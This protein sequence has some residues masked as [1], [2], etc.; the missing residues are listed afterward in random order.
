MLSKKDCQSRRSLTCGVNY[1]KILKN[2]KSLK[3][4]LKCTL[5]NEIQYNN[6]S[7]IYFIIIAETFHNL[8]ISIFIPVQYNILM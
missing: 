7:Y 2:P 6:I 1:Y 8:L 4:K 3:Q 5:I